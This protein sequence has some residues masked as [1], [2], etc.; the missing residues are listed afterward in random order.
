[1][2]PVQQRKGNIVVFTLEYVAREKIDKPLAEIGAQPEMLPLNPGH[3]RITGVKRPDRGRIERAIRRNLIGK[4]HPVVDG[5]GLR[6]A[7]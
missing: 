4:S 1:M 6:T 2:H 7:I 5:T 3:D